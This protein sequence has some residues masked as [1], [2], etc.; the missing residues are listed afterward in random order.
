MWVKICYFFLLEM[1]VMK[2]IVFMFVF[3]LG[4]SGV[5]LV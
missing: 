3:V 1:F 2:M 4:S 5:V